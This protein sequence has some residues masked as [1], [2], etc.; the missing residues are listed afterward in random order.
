[1]PN[2]QYLWSLLAIL[3][4]AACTTSV[5]S[6]SSLSEQEPMEM[7]ELYEHRDEYYNRVITVIGK[8]TIGGAAHAGNSFQLSDQSDPYA[9]SGHYMSEE[10]LN[11]VW[12][13][14]KKAIAE[15]K[16]RHD[17][18]RVHY[19]YL[20]LHLLAS[21]Y[22]LRG[23]ESVTVP[24]IYNVEVSMTKVL[25]SM[26]NKCLVVSGYFRN[27]AGEWHIPE[28]KYSGE[29]VPITMKPCDNSD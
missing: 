13:E 25:G 19:A 12:E 15:D 23:I 2:K 5:S 7:S 16:K 6:S 18:K 10:E 14:R 29:L 17:G 24:E 9:Y 3:S 28:A 8:M 22:D 27:R 20:K 11:L 21:V 4:L 26:Q 1:M